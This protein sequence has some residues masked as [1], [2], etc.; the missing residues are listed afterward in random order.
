MANIVNL[1]QMRAKN[2]FKACENNIFVGKDGG[3][4]VKNLPPKIRENGI[5]GALAFALSK[6]DKEVA[7]Y[8]M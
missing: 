6:K 4:V 2:A 3:E 8:N 1:D 5:L 7:G